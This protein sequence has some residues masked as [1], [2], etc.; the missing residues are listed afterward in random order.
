MAR[1]P[2]RSDASSE[3]GITGEIAM[4]WFDQLRMRA[5]MVFGRGR[6]ATHLNDELAFHLDRQKSGSICAGS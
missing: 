1:F 3:N 6:A 2:A 4:R 5:L